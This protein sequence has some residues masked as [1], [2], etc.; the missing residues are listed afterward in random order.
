LANSLLYS[1]QSLDGSTYLLEWFDTVF[2]P[3]V[4]KHNGSPF[5]LLLD[6]APGHFNGFPNDGIQVEF[7]PPNCTS[8]KQ[9]C[10]Q[11]IINALK[12]RYKF[13]Y[14]RDVLCFY[15]LSDDKKGI[16][17]T[18]GI[19]LKSGSTGIEYGNLPHLMDAAKYINSVLPISIENCFGKA[20]V[21]IQFF[22][23]IKS[24]KET[25]I[26]EHFGKRIDGM[27]DFIIYDITEF[28]HVDDPTL[29]EL[30]EAIMDDI[31]DLVDMM[32]IYHCLEEDSK[33]RCKSSM[34]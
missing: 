31:N 21:S 24:I 14:L 27:S 26:E 25:S 23:D 5:L 1:A 20:D 12:T 9:P 10:D 16:L 7:F 13:Q 3:E 34:I 32:N 19:H 6:N 33:M 11:G 4:Q 18:L 15:D 29:K 22:D 2:L 30:T 17:Q 8:W 28:I